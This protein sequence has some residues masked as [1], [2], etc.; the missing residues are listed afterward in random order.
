MCMNKMQKGVTPLA[1]AAYRG[2][3]EICRLLL[4]HGADLDLETDNLDT[5]FSLAVFQNHPEAAMLLLKEGA[6]VNH[7]DKVLCHVIVIP[8]ILCVCK[9]PAL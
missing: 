9:Q 2:K 4:S 5:P 7:E 8:L 3:T 6:D 1:A